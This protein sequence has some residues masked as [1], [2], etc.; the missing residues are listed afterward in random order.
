MPPEA[1]A[2]PARAAQAANQPAEAA[3]EANALEGGKPESRRPD[4]RTDLRKFLHQLADRPQ[5][6]GQRRQDRVQRRQQGG[7]QRRADQA[8]VVLEDLELP[9][10]TFQKGLVALID[11]AADPCVTSCSMA[12]SSLSLVRNGVR[13][14]APSSPKTS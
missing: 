6:L 7:H 2:A 11:Q 5:Q 9:A 12:R 3:H 1:A 14:A 10:T 4:G 13:P 8:H